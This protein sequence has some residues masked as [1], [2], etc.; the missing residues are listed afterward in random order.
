MAASVRFDFNFYGEDQVTRTLLRYQERVL[1]AR[2][3]FDEIINQLQRA[4]TQQF[5]SEGDYGSAGWAPLSPAYAAAKA[6]HYPGKPILERSGR[7]VASLTQP[8]GGDA[9]RVSEPALMIFGTSVPYAK[10]H[11][12]GTTKMPRR[13][14]VEL[15]ESVRADLVKTLQRFIQTGRAV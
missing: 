3:A 7:L 4:E 11:Q 10:Y 15:P 5:A 12:K 8:V 2:P 1:D 13:R 6:R 9:V 14:P